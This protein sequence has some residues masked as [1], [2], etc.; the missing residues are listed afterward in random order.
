[1]STLKKIICKIEDIIT[2]TSFLAMTL[3]VFWSV[4][5][6]YVLKI[7]F[8][9]GEEL[10]RYLMI[11]SIYFGVSIGVRRGTHLGIKAFVG[12]LPEKIRKIAEKIEV[13]STTS[14]FVILF[15]LSM[16]MVLQLKSTGQVSTMLRI[17]MYIVYLA[18]PIGFA[19]SSF[20][21]VE[22]TIAEFNKG[23]NI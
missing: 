6:R 15:I 21:S 18:L 7:P 8:T 19:I 22:N 13:I 5:C 4:I 12:I 2:I 16:Q 17:P 23:E 3:V 11:Y 9:S 10:A 20:H 14:M 1:M